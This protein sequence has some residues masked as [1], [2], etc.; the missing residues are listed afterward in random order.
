MRITLQNCCDSGLWQKVGFCNTDI[1]RISADINRSQEILIP[2]FGDT[3]PVGGWVRVVWNVDRE[4]PFISLP[5]TIARIINLDVCRTPVRVNN[6]WIEFLWGSMVRLQDVQSANCGCPTMQAFDRGNFPTA[7]DIPEGSN[8][9]LRVYTTD[10]RD[11]GVQIFFAGAKDQ[12]GTFIYEDGQN[13]CYLTYASP[14]ATTSFIV[15]EFA[16]VQKTR[17]Y[18][19]IILKA[20]DA[21]T[22]EETLLA[23]FTRDEVNPTYRRYLLTGLPTNCCNADD[24]ETVQVTALAKLE[25]MP[26]V[27][28]TDFLI[29]Q[30]K[31]A[32]IL[33]AQANRLDGADGLANAAQAENYHN[34]A[35]R[36][37]QWELKHWAGPYN[38]AV[39]VAPFGTATLARQS[40]GYLV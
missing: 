25:V 21:T 31:E 7:Y 4:D 29:I 1:T 22:G 8:S 14:F 26:V 37:L 24:P 38:P 15:T 39:V 6:E 34:R 13:G 36:Q 17:T 33:Q 40:V 11:N 19:D 2:L 20:V 5:P 35:V 27:R 23:R 28:P 10:A 12:N 16:G 32:L 3:G 30:S 18:G 9:L